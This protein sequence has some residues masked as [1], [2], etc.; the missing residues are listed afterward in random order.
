ML[1]VLLMI[2][3][4]AAVYAA[5]PRHA[6][7]RR[8]ISGRRVERNVGRLCVFEGDG[9]TVHLYDLDDLDYLAVLTGREGYTL[10]FGFGADRVGILEGERGVDA[11]L[12]SLLRDP[13]QGADFSRFGEAME[14][15]PGSRFV[16]LD[17]RSGDPD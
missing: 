5:V 15:T 3:I 4:G 7:G 17:R 16:F 13:P 1:Y 2:G 11:V 6:P 8:Y 9:E 14:A 10:Q 12:G